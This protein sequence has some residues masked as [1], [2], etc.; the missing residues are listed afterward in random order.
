MA[1]DDDSDLY[2]RMPPKKRIVRQYVPLEEYE[3][4]KAKNKEMRA[5]LERLIRAGWFADEEGS[6]FRDARAFL[7][8]HPKE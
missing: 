5:L 4:L 6:A 7:A 3:R 8:E 2:V 1:S